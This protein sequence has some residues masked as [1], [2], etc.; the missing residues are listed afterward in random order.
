MSNE[1]RHVA[2]SLTGEPITYPKINEMIDDF[3]KRKISTFMVTNGQYPEAMK[4]LKKVTQLYLSVDGTN[5]KQ[6]K[7][8]NPMDR[9]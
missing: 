3:H 6:L 2:L 1:V 9:L 7:A 4:N 8:F 5:Q